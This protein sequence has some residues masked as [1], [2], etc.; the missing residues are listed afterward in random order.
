MFGL[1]ALTPLLGAC[2]TTIP[3]RVAEPAPA[4]VAEPLVIS[5]ACLAPPVE[6]QPVEEPPMPEALPRPGGEPGAA[7]WAE[8]MTYVD[9]RRERAELAG[10]FYEGERNAYQRSEEHTSKLQSR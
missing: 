10:L 1:A 6:V 9:R 7:N 8:W 5:P 2:G 4:P 3:L